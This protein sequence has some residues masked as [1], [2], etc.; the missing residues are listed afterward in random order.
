MNERARWRH[1]RLLYSGL[2]TDVVGACIVFCYFQLAAWAR[3]YYS[4]DSFVVVCNGVDEEK[5]AQVSHWLTGLLKSGQLSQPSYAALTQSLLRDFPLIG[6]VSWSR[7]N[8]SCLTCTVAP[9]APVFRINNEYV[10]ATNGCVYHR[11]LFDELSDSLPAITVNESWLASQRFARVYTFIMSIPASVFSAY[12]CVY[13]DPYRVVMT[14]KNDLDLPYRCVCVVDERSVTLL[15]D[16]VELMSRC[17]DKEEHVVVF[18]FR[19][20]GSV[21]TKCIT[22]KQYTQLQRV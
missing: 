16:V 3:N 14:P 6:K 1:R 9:V 4:V 19:F 10:A 18:D 20:S 11:S 2:V 21:I 5:A 15:P 8:P 12:D 22:H 17:Q 13:H 7:Y